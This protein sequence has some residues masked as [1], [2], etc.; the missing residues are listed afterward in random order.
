MR[1]YKSFN[2]SV[3]VAF[4]LCTEF[5]F[6]FTFLFICLPLINGLE[7]LNARN[8]KRKARRTAMD[9]SNISYSWNMEKN[10]Y[11]LRSIA[12]WWVKKSKLSFKN[13]NITKYSPKSPSWWKS[14]SK[15]NNFFQHDYLCSNL[16]FCH[17]TGSCFQN[18][19][20]IFQGSINDHIKIPYTKFQVSMS[21]GLIYRL[22]QN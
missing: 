13:H 1:L 18:I 7:T 17:K 6:P 5:M 3:F 2:E 14:T 11:L 16:S 12:A 10:W 22:F 19:E 15:G 9:R 4:L 20:K 8:F 21:F